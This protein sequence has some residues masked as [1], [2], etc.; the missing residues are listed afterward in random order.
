MN[1]ELKEITGKKYTQCVIHPKMGGYTQCVYMG[2]TGKR[3]T[4]PQDND[5]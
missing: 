3:R 2:V 1:I 4:T 5:S